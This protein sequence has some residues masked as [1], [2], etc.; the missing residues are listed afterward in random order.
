M[1]AEQRPALVLNALDL[2]FAGAD[3]GHHRSFPARSKTSPR[4]TFEWQVSGDESEAS[5]GSDRPQGDTE[6]ITHNQTL[7]CCRCR[8]IGKL[9]ACE[10]P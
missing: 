5:F 9:P 7:R 10:P 1:V 8:D 2:P 3:Y 6:D 4:R